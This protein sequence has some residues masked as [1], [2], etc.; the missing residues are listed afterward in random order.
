LPSIAC[1]CHPSP[2]IHHLPSIACHPSPAITCHRLPSIACHLSPAITCHHLP[3][4]ACHS[5]PAITCHPSPA[6]TCIHRL[7]CLRLPSPAIQRL[8]LPSIACDRRPS[9][10][11]YRHRLPSPAITCLLRQSLSGGDNV[12]S[13]FPSLSEMLGISITG[14][15]TCEHSRLDT[16]HGVQCGVWLTSCFIAVPQPSCC[17]NNTFADFTE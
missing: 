8:P 5:S 16:R 2:A 13:T 12:F 4:I 6:I 7:A 11:I 1:A 9:P 14:Q 15:I 3:F 10:A 17:T